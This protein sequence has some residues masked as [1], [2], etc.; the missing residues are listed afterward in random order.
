MERIIFFDINGTI[1]QRDARTD[2]PYELAIDDYLQLENG[3][4]GVDTSAR[5]DKDVFREVLQNCGKEFS[6]PLWQGF[7]AV[8]QAYLEKY[9]KT[10]IWRANVDVKEWLAEISSSEFKLAL[11]SGEL[12]LGAEYKLRKLGV[13]HYFACGGFG[14]DG[15]QRFQIADAALARAEKLYQCKFEQII[16]IGDTILD[17]KTARHLQGKII[18]IATGSNSYEELAEQKPDLL[19]RNFSEIDLSAILT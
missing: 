6:E 13:W 19:V 8:Y 17:I 4:K 7:L 11:I 16:V 10:D 1:I 3:M 14:E 15:L 12:S 9:S 5:S 2:L 18:S